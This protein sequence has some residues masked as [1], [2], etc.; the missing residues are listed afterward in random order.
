MFRVISCTITLSEQ[1]PTDEDIILLQSISWCRQ[2]TRHYI[3]Q[4]WPRSMTAYGATRQ[5]YLKQFMNNTLSEKLDAFQNNHDIT[6]I[7]EHNILKINTSR[8]SSSYI[9]KSTVASRILILCDMA[10]HMAMMWHP[11]DK[12]CNNKIFAQN[13]RFVSYQNRNGTGKIRKYIN[14]IN[15]SIRIKW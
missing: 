1:N 4:C 8:I 6:V 7:L 5:K 3:S 2:A 11:S 14:K 9:D 13:G 12:I 10:I 15:D